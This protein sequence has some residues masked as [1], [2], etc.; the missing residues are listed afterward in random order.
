MSRARNKEIKLRFFS[1]HFSIGKKKRGE[2]SNTKTFKYNC[3]AGEFFFAWCPHLISANKELGSLIRSQNSSNHPH[4]CTGFEFSIQWF[5]TREKSVQNHHFHEIYSKPT[6]SYFAGKL[7]K[8]I[9]RFTLSLSEQATEWKH[10]RG[11]VPEP[12]YLVWLWLMHV[13][14]IN[15]LCKYKHE[16]RREERVYA[17][18]LYRTVKMS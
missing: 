9:Q 15:Y 13:Y 16:H 7:I 5:D 1:S 18:L 14:S 10:K 12:S 2:L 4:F 11:I 8:Y 17:K 3:H 6:N